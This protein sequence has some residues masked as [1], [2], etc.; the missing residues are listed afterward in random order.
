MKSRQ[1]IIDKYKKLQD[2]NNNNFIL[3]IQ[4]QILLSLVATWDKIKTT[5]KKENYTDKTS[6]IDIWNNTDYSIT[7]WLEISNLTLEEIVIKKKIKVLIENNL[8][9]PDNTLHRTSIQLL[10]TKY[11]DYMKTYEEYFKKNEKS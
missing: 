8:I 10:K 5:Y 4:D 7:D 1:S 3:L 11:I 9:Y 2:D 6:L